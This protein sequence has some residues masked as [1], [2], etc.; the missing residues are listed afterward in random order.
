M[1]CRRACGNRANLTGFAY[2][3]A[4]E[5]ADALVIPELPH[6]RDAAT[7]AAASV[8]L[9]KKPRG[10][11]A[12]EP[13]LSAARFARGGRSSLVWRGIFRPLLNQAFERVA[14]RLD[15]SGSLAP[16]EA[17]H[18]IRQRYTKRNQGI[19]KIVAAGYRSEKVERMTRL[20]R[21][22]KSSARIPVDIFVTH[23]AFA[24][25]GAIRTRRASAG[26]A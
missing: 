1:R 7:F 24:R 2:R 22:M 10:V 15:G 8:I 23:R 19:A 12:P 5:M 11:F 18:A 14:G 9:R 20:S 13:D 3:A 4:G 25:A 26:E 21:L 16:C 17:L 6:E